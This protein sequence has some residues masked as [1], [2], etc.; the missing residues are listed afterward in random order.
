MKRAVMKAKG[1]DLNNSHAKFGKMHFKGDDE[2]QAF[3]FALNKYDESRVQT[4][5]QYLND[6][7]Q[8]L[9]CIYQL[10]ITICM[11]NSDN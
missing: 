5:N 1:I 8:M 7:M 2:G 10:L 3:F 6:K 9:K 11:D 4:S